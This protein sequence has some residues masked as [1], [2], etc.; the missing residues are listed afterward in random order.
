MDHRKARTT[1]AHSRDVTESESRTESEQRRATRPTTRKRPRPL[2][3]RQKQILQLMA[4]LDSMQG[5]VFRPG[6]RGFE[7]RWTHQD[8]RLF[9]CYQDPELFLEHRGLI[10]THDTNRGPLFRITEAGRRRVAAM[11]EDYRHWSPERASYGYTSV[12][13]AAPSDADTT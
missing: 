3:P 1:D 11:R 8:D 4:E 12:T 7:A 5:A 9:R 13:A 6:T 10:A 2:T